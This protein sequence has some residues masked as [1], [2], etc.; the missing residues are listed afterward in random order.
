MGERKPH[1]VPGRR[2]DGASEFQVR[3]ALD[4]Y[5]REVANCRVA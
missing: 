4:T 2:A 3:L 1:E 5:L